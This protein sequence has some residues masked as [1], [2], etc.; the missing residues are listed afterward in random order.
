MVY[1]ILFAQPGIELAL[2]AMKVRVPH[3]WTDR[4]FSVHH[5]LNIN[6]LSIF[7]FKDITFYITK[8]SFVTNDTEKIL[9][10]KSVST[11]NQILKVSE[12]ETDFYFSSCTYISLHLFLL[13][14][15]ESLLI[16]PA[17]LL[18]VDR[19]VSILEHHKE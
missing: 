10:L 4:E 3:H 5:L 12:F 14:V 13:V 17:D 16:S 9:T 19:N 15:W 2:L 18:K 11:C 6:D 1:G 7:L 8:L